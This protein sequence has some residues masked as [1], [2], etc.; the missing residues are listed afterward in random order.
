MIYL[1]QDLTNQSAALQLG[2]ILFGNQGNRAYQ[3]AG[4]IARPWIIVGGNIIQS[5]AFHGGR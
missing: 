3:L 4:T 1:G 5:L 2:S